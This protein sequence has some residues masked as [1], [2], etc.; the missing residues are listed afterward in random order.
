MRLD[1]VEVRQFRSYTE[2]TFDLSPGLTVLRGANGSGKTNLLEAIGYLADLSS[3]RGAPTE[4][5]VRF[6][7]PVHLDDVDSPNADAEAPTSTVIRGFGSIDA[8]RMEIETEIGVGRRNRTL[9]NKQPVTRVRDAAEALRVSVFSPDDLV[10]VKGGPAERRRY[11]DELGAR[12]HPRNDALLTEFDRVLRQRNALLKQCAGRLDSSAALTL[13]VWDAKLAT[14]GTRVAELRRSLVDRLTPAVSQAYADIADRRAPVVMTIRPSWS[15]SLDDALAAG[16]TTDVRRGVSLLGPHRDDIEALIE[17]RPSR[18]HSSQGEQRTLS[19]ALRLAAHRV[20]GE[21]L[22]RMPLL[23]LDDV[24]SELDPDRSDALV[25]H[26]PPGQSV[27]A[28]AGALPPAAIVES[29]VEI[30]RDVTRGSRVVVDN[31]GETVEGKRADDRGGSSAQV[32][33]DVDE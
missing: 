21:E 23:L 16:R 11:L 6:A 31:A 24:F 22:G 27:L 33:A 12:L 10:L 25:R 5:L 1:R 18:T 30:R 15:G 14:V 2:A 7:P 4:A 9:I 3:F 29:L 28:T 13:D 26:L 32:S 19:L 20:V 8:R 17:G